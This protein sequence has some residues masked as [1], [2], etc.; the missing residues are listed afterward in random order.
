MVT[1][2]ADSPQSGYTA[3][4]DSTIQCDGS[5]CR[6]LRQMFVELH[7]F[8]MWRWKARKVLSLLQIRCSGLVLTIDEK[9]GKSVGK[10]GAGQ[11]AYQLAVEELGLLPDRWF[12]TLD[13]FACSGDLETQDSAVQTLSAIRTIKQKFPNCHTSLG[14]SNVS[15]GFS[16]QARKILNSVFLYHALQAGLDMAILNA[17]DLIPYPE[18][19]GEEKRKAEQLIFHNSTQVLA[20]FIDS[21]QKKGNPTSKPYRSKF[22]HNRSR[23]KDPLANHHPCSGKGSKKTSPPSFRRIREK[24]S[25]SS[26]ACPLNGY[27]LPAMKDVGEQFG[28]G[29]SFCLSFCN[30]QKSCVLQQKKLQDIYKSKDQDTLGSV[31]YWQLCMGGCA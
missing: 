6:P 10:A 12:L 1:L 19:P 11:G 4:I 22:V 9:H 3:V 2:V 24:G 8:R 31:L 7:Q 23:R 16:K 13:L 14:I 28:T 29:R 27:L 20:D 5:P 25:P 15:Y 30:P 21:L 17:A 18:I 26:C